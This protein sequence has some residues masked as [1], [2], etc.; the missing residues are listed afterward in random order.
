M[1]RPAIVYGRGGG[2]LE[3]A[4]AG[5]LRLGVHGRS[6]PVREVA[7]AAG[8]HNSALRSARFGARPR[9]TK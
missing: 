3:R 9:L 5:S 4:P 1:I 7:A 8:S 2:I 6:R